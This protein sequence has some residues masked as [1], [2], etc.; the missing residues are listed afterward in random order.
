MKLK[1]KGFLALLALTVT[2]HIKATT[3]YISPNGNDN[4]AGTSAST[5]WKTI[6]RLNTVALAPGDVVLFEGGQTF[7]GKIS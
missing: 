7:S 1:I 5:P 4:A 2:T 3:Y 6:N